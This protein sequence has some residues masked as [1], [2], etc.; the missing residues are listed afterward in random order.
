MRGRML[1]SGASVSIKGQVR[2]GRRRHRCTSSPKQHRAAPVVEPEVG[3]DLG[4]LAARRQRV[5]RAHVAEHPHAL[6]RRCR[7]HG[8]HAVLKLG[9]VAAPL[10]P[11]HGE[12][13]ARDGALGEAFEG[14]VVEAGFLDQL[15]RGLPAVAGEARAGAYPYLLGCHHPL[16]ACGGRGCR[17]QEAAP[18]PRAAWI[19]RQSEAGLSGRSV[20]SISKGSSASQMALQ[21]VP[22]T[23]D[24]RPSPMPRLPSGV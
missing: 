24:G 1:S 12:R 14:D 15:H 21:S 8:T 6:R 19:L 16:P 11:P 3:R 2:T 20:I 17:D 4:R 18:L 10:P 13:L 22:G 5:R 7:Q 23:S 9:V